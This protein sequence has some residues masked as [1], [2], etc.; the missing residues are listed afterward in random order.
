VEYLDFQNLAEHREFRLRVFEPGGWREVRLSIAIAAFVAHQVSLQDGPDV[1][2]QM[3]MRAIANGET[4]PDVITI[5]D[6]DIARYREAQP[7]GPKH[8]S[9]PPLSP[10]TPPLSPR[11]AARTPAPARHA[12]ALVTN[13][14]LPGLDEG[15]RVSH[16]IFG[17]GVTT[18]S[19]AG[20][21]AVC[22]DNGGTKTF[23]TSMLQVDVLSAPHTWETGRRGTP[24]PCR[25][26]APP[27]GEPG[28]D[29]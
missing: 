26:V 5:D 12:P 16:A 10:P 3:L 29:S 4:A 22:F 28:K 1:C 13:E 7:R 18:P 17:L 21:T 11:P 8:R 14:P 15:Q 2:Y 19:S 25:A 20:H 24:R 27:T 9:S 6:L 23:V